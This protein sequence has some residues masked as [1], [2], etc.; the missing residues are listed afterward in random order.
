MRRPPTSL[1]ARPLWRVASIASALAGGV[2]LLSLVGCSQEQPGPGAKQANAAGPD[3]PPPPAVLVTDAVVR[4]TQ[5]F[6]EYTGRTRAADS[7]EIRA[8]VSGYLKDSP[9][10]KYS[11]TDSSPADETSSQDPP[12][13]SDDGSS[14]KTPAEN[15]VDKTSDSTTPKVTVSEGELVENKT[16]LFLIDPEPY[17]LALEQAEGN[18]QAAEARLL[19][20]EKDFKR[21]KEL[22]DRNAISNAELDQASAA[23]AEVRGQIENL[24]A[25]RDRAKVDLGYTRVTSPIKGLLGQSLVTDGNL[26]TADQTILTSVVSQNPIYV[27]FDVDEQSLLDYRRRM[28]E[29][30]VKGARES[31]ILVQLKLANEQGYPHEGR[32]DFVNNRTDPNTGNTTLRATFNNAQGK[33]SPGLFARVKLPFTEEYQAVQV[34]TVAIGMDQQGRYVMVVEDGVAL[35]RSIQPGVVDGDFT[36]IREGLQEGETVIISGLQKVRNKTSVTI[37]RGNDEQDPAQQNPAL[38]ESVEQDATEKNS[39]EQASAESQS[40]DPE[41]PDRDAKR[42]DAE[43]SGNQAVTAP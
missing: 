27:D 15:E 33:L 28:R 1:D 29:G 10:S 39:T 19:Q 43:T 12:P 21:A 38:P 13:N 36:V 2:A 42:N 37:E 34:P 20:A 14:S 41:S 25:I 11:P 9:R 22:S 26:I 7:V 30:K 31:T 24:K 32:I 5:E 8:R 4:T 6:R 35:R 23:L 40:G 17:E 16:L 3:K 18:L